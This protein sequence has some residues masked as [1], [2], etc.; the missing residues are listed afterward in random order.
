MGVAAIAL[1]AGAPSAGAAVS[2]TATGTELEVDG[3]AG[4]N[5]IDVVCDT[6]ATVVEGDG[7]F[8]PTPILCQDLTRLEVSASD[9]D[10]DVSVRAVT[11]AN[12]FDEPGLSGSIFVEG[13]A[14]RDRVEASE[15]LL[16]FLYGGNGIDRLI[17]GRGNDSMSGAAGADT[18]KGNGGADFIKGKSGGDDLVGGKGI[19]FILGGTGR[20]SIS[21][22]KRIDCLRGGA[23]ADLISSGPG[24]DSV[25]GGPGR[26][27]INQ[28][29]RPGD[30]F[31]EARCSA[32]AL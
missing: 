6:G 8:M 13:D 27:R 2:F 3:D 24:R 9:G 25:G 18:I 21:G 15:S 20:D 4:A 28:G 29:P 19:D 22:G 5:T 10:D 26:D 12:S 30:T 7:A 16:S 11:P 31:S 32:A 17:G 14:G 1:C 23:G